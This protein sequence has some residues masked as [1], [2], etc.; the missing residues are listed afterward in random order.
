M[1]DLVMDV[2]QHFGHI[3]IVSFIGGIVAMLLGALV[4]T[5]HDTIYM[6]C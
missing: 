5:L 2:A 6:A 3:Y 4:Q 1:I